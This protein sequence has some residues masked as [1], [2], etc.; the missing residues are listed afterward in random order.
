MNDLMRGYLGAVAAS[1]S[2]AYAT[3]RALAP[4][5]SGLKGAKMIFASAFLNYVAAAIPGAVNCGLM[6]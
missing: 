4:Q 2:I 1:M 6:R 3:R 5:L